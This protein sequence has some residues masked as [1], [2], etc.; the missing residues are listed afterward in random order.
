MLNTPPPTDVPVTITVPSGA[1]R[2][3]AVLSRIPDTILPVTAPTQVWS[4]ELNVV[5]GRVSTT[6]PQVADAEAYTLT[7]TRVR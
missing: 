7:L 4:Q 2:Y 5:S 6:L 1:R 3:R